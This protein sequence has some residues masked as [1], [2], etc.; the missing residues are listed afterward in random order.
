MRESG[1]PFRYEP[2]LT[3][4]G[5]LAFAVI[6]AVDLKLSAVYPVSLAN[7]LVVLLGLM[8]KGRTMT[9][10]LAT[11]ATL[12]VCVVAAAEVASG[13]GG[14]ALVNG[15]AALAVL[16][17]VAALVLLLHRARG[18]GRIAGDLLGENDIYQ[19]VFNQTFQFV[20]ALD[21][22]GGVLE[23][24]ETL[25]DYAGLGSEG[26]RAMPI[27][28]L[29]IFEGDPRA[30]ERLRE[31]VQAA[32]AGDFVRDEFVVSGVGDT[33]AV[34]D[35][36]LKPIRKDDAV[37]RLIME[38]RDVT[39]IRLQQKMLVQSQKMEVVGAL[40]AGVAHDFNNLLSVIAG[41]LELL[42]KRMNGDDA[43]RERL[44]RAIRA[45]FRGRALTHQL[46]A[47][48]RRQALNPEVVDVNRLL[49]G[50]SEM[51]EALGDSIRVDVDLP[52]SLPPCEIDP[53]LLDTALMNVAINARDG[54][55]N[56]GILRIRTA[57]ATLGESGP[58]SGIDLPAGDYVMIE[59]SDTGTG[60]PE[61][62]AAQVFEPFFTTKPEGQGTGL[63]LSM[64]YG[65]VRQSGGDVV[66]KSEEGVGTSVALYL[67]VTD[68][69][70]PDDVAAID[71]EPAAAVTDGK[72]VFVVE[73][74]A[75]VRDIILNVLLD[76]GCE[77]ETAADGEEAL[78][79]IHSGARYD[80]L[81][82]DMAMPGEADGPDVARAARE[83][84]PDLPV[85]FCSGYPNQIARGRRPPIPGALFLVKP[86][87]DAELI[88]AVGSALGRRV[89]V[90]GGPSAPPGGPP[91]QDAFGHPE[92]AP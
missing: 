40:T 27:W 49:R 69:P 29:P 15:G 35:L 4:V 67:P 46:L 62:V 72:T 6:A 87:H 44:D 43:V 89:P 16:W 18:A 50:M 37:R 14:P 90:A 47:F 77:V 73:D 91:G 38:G 64:V 48:S 39:E 26:M 70:L 65:F 80:L 36:S 30:R 85:I 84:M 20:A 75:E 17:L 21:A 11:L 13:A 57:R 10:V 55:P 3:L 53:D 71:G 32:S 28:M 45:V 74:D 42:G 63:G 12:A 60:M 81:I 58:A 78:H 59:V 23:A 31:A 8:A 52:E 41:N 83:A 61:D 88:E 7:A 92:A 5:A 76:A 2:A 1:L 82:A 66:L 24:N 22:D 51:Y 56:G 34:I 54:M 33:Q 9:L 86:F 79:A 68:K 19:A 25:R